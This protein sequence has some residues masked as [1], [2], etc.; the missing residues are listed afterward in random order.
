MA[1][2]YNLTE[3][4]E[5][6][7]GAILLKWIH[8]GN[9]MFKK[10]TKDGIFKD[11]VLT[12]IFFVKRPMDIPELE[13]EVRLYDYMYA[14]CIDGKL[15]QNEFKKWCSNNYSKIFCWFNDVLYKET[16][17]LVDKGKVTYYKG[18]RINLY[19]C[20]EVDSSM[21]EVAE[22]MAGLK[23]F[24]KEF[25]II[26]KREPIDV[27]LWNEYLMYAQ[28]FG[29]ADEIDNQFMKLYPEVITD[30]DSI[31]YDFSDIAFIRSITNN[32]IRS[33]SNARSRV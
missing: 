29:M 26:D 2:N 15:E 3:K 13:M 28:I 12:N 1:Y 11:K 6:F 27:S 23:K 32:G 18:K 22:Q 24:L 14:A 10:V 16:L 25:S 9:V 31:G 8:D 30:M 4:K 20:F 17:E 7:L 33:D 21:M 5:D 19:K